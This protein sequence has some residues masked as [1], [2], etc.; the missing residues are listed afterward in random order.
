MSTVTKTS[1]A[2]APVSRMTLAKKPKPPTSRFVET[3]V[4]APVLIKSCLVIIAGMVAASLLAPVIAPFDPADQD[5]LH[6]L[7]GPSANHWF[8]TDHLGRDVLSRVLHGARI[9]IG[10]ATFGAI[11]GLLLGALTGLIAGYAGGRSDNAIMFL[12]DVQQSLPFIVLCLAVIAMFGANLSTLLVLVSLAGWEV[13][14]RFARAST[15][16]TKESQYIVAARSIGVPEHRILLRHVLPN[17]TAPLIV[18]T[19]LNITSIILLES[20]LS[21]LGVGVQPPTPS[22]GG[23]ISEGRQYLNNAWWIVLGPSAAMIAVTLSV[24]LSGDWLRDLFDPTTR[25]R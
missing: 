11:A 19:T 1:T 9:S 16:A 4:S 23:M 5:L 14:A 17:I 13:Y 10:V 8:G 18:I 12:V 3:L 21:F 15:L 20:S 24:S 7:A 25:R 2:L 22:W 6:R